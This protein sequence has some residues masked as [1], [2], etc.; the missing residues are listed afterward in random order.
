LLFFRIAHTLSFTWNGISDDNATN[1]RGRRR[2]PAYS[3]GL[4]L[5]PK[6]GFYD[7]FVIMLDFNS[8]YPS[9]IQEFNLCFTTVEHWR[10]NEQGIAEVPMSGLGTGVL[11]RV[12]RHLVERRRAVKSLMKNEKD[13]VKLQQLEIKQKAFKL[14][15]NSMYGCLGFGSSRFCCTPIASL[16]T[17][18]GRDILQKTVDMVQGALS[19]NVIYGDT[20]S[21][22]VFTNTSELREA[23]EMGYRIKREVNKLY[24]LLE[25]ELDGTVCINQWHALPCKN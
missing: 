6:K 8:L 21:M 2:K 3:G 23:R 7:K 11:P 17:A 25:I 1:S 22:F 13:G 18:Q 19:L 15:A 14:I 16:I 20:D 5:E 12:L 10:P 24:K 9:I 4:V